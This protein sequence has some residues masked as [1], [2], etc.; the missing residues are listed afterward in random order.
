MQSV[1]ADVPVSQV[2]T[3]SS[4]VDRSLVNERLIARLLSA[5]AVLALILAA[6]GLY[7]V[8]GYSVARRTGEI[9]LRLALGATR[10]G[11]LR[12][13]L[14][15]SRDRRGDRFG[16]RASPAAMLLS[17]PLSGLLY[18]VTPSDPACAA[19]AQSPVCSS[20]PWPPPPYRRGAPR[21]S[22][23][24]SRCGTS[25]G[26]YVTSS[27]VFAAS[28]EIWS[29][30]R[31]VER[32]LDDELQRARSKCSSRNIDR[33]AWRQ[34]RR[35]A[36]RRLQLGRVESI[37]E[38]VRDVK[39]GAFVDGWIQDVR[40]AV[41]LLRRGPLF[42]VFAIASLALGIGA[43]GAIF[44]LFD[45]IALRRLNVPEPDRLVVASWGK[46]GARFNYSLP[47]PQFGSH[48]A[49]QHD[50]RCR[51]L[52]VSVR[53]GGRHGARASLRRRTAFW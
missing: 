32:E 38:Q 22:I 29:I 40:Y 15:Q 2:R 18:G 24:S 14:R 35:A 26:E 6:V 5:F 31:R 3:L 30:A 16:G 28:G 21:A 48:Q 1:A 8:L 19:P 43:T 52:A 37:K 44:S 17:R 46:P 41:R 45:G 13:V 34:T 20:S 53:Q 49:A 12:S 47:Y 39:A 4:Q 50:A 25:E 10:G 27:P 51:L 42:A 33:P 23:R 9:G 36:P 7:G 11:V